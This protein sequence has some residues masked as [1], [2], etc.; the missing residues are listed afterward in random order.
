VTSVRVW[1]WEI[2]SGVPNLIVVVVVGC[3]SFPGDGGGGGDDDMVF[4]NSDLGGRED[5]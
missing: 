2:D 4:L 1:I 3:S 5:G